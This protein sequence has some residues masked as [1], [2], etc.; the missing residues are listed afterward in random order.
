M[1]QSHVSAG[2]PKTH[3][4]GE[5]AVPGAASGR[6][7]LSERRDCYLDPGLGGHPSKPWGH[8]LP[9]AY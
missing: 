1:A 8:P 2:D 6:P 4:G 7:P 3:T 5:A 9:G